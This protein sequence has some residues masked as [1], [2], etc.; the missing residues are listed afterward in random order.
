MQRCCSGRSTSRKESHDSAGARTVTVDYII[1][2][3]RANIGRAT[4]K[5]NAMKMR[6][7][8]I[9]G[10]T[11]LFSIA[12]AGSAVAGG[13]GWPPAPGTYRATDTGASASLVGPSTI[14]CYPPKG[15][16]PQ[17]SAFAYVNVDRGLHTFKPRGSATLV[18]QSGTM[19]N[20]YLSS[21]SG[22]NVN[23]CWIIA[24]GDFTVAK[25]LSSA[26][27]STT[28]PGDS[29][30]PG[31]PMKVSATNVVT[32][33]GGGGGGGG[34]TG[35]ITLNL[36]W[37]YKGIV[38]HVRDDGKF[39][40]GSFSTASG[41]DSDRATAV[42]QGQITGTDALTSEYASIEHGSSSQVVKGTPVDACFF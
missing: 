7:L 2:K 28:V 35:P 23:G 8:P 24:D 12:L 41:F 18:Q 6:L 20:L 40:C 39:T 36:S 31:M 27:L 30:C 19:L 1:S 13:G 32:V 34:G 21:T 42:T 25:D 15:C 22:T 9:L 29:N 3:R 16:F 17:P 33:K 11:G 10:I 4:R 5:D 26:S 14:V 38:S 37:T